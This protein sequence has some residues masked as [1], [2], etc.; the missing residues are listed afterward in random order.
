MNLQQSIDLSARIY[1]FNSGDLFFR[2]KKLLGFSTE[3][4]VL[5][6][7]DVHFTPCAT[8]KKKDPRIQGLSKLIKRLILRI[9]Q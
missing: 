7:N 8:G 9:A 5:L 2:C 6:R 4:I 3:A 1:R